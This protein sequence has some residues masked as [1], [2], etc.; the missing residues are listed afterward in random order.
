MNLET[1]RQR[2]FDRSSHIPS[3]KQYRV[4][5]SACEALVVN[6]CPCHETG[7][8]RAT[9]ECA[10]CSEVIPSQRRYCEACE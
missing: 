3:T 5:C 8:D 6:G 10:G 1:L 2:G 4:R 9:H 7:C